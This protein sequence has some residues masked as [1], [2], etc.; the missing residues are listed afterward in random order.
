MRAGV[1]RDD[2]LCR[3]RGTA[4]QPEPGQLLVR[5]LARGICGSDLHFVRR[6]QTI[7]QINDGLWPTLGPAA[8]GYSHVDLSKDVFIGHEFCAEV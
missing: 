5:T 1:L 6:A 8:V 7:V 4:P 3:G 2:R